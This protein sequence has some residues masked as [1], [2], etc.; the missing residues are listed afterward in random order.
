MVDLITVALVLIGLVL[1][2]SGAALSIYGV[3]LLGI[4]LGAGGGYLIAPEVGGIIGVAEP[5][6]YILTAGTGALLGAILAYAVLSLAVA[7]VSLGAGIYLGNVVLV[8]DFIE[9]AWYVEWGAALGVGLLL[10]LLTLIFTK[11]VMIIVTSAIGSALAS[12]SVTM[13]DIQMVHDNATIEPILFDPYAPL[14]IGL[15]VLG[16]LSQVGLFRLGYVTRLA[17]ILP[18]AS[19]LRNKN[20]EET[21]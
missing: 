19:V 3:A 12:R 8:P 20:E 18:G 17:K 7:V 9:G 6:S 11:T 15:F 1:L 5:V 21:N 13:D 4:V 16:V 2:F 10:A 14:F